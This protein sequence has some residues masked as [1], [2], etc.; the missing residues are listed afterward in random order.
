MNFLRPKTPLFSVILYIIMN[1]K[2]AQIFEI[3]LDKFLKRSILI[4]KT[5]ARYVSVRM[6]KAVS[7]DFQEETL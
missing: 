4:K 2:K 5:F 7:A 1:Y 6:E 3:L